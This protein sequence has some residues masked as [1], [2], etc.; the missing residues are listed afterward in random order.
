MLK[1]HMM[2]LIGV[3]AGL[4]IMLWGCAGNLP[5]AKR[6]EILDTNWGKSVETAK[7]DQ[8]LNPD[9]GKEPTPVVGLDGKVAKDQMDKYR[10]TL[11]REAEVKESVGVG[12]QVTPMGIEAK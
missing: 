3:L 2:I 1:G 10:K 8:I 11:K 6:A 4:S 7:S 5:E 9:A 12:L